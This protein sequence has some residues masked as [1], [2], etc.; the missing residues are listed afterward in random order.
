MFPAPTTM[1]S[2]SPS[3]CTATIS[4]ASAATVSGSSPYSRSPIRASP[5]SLSRRRRKAS[6]PPSGAR[7]AASSGRRLTLPG[8]REPPERH[9]ACAGLGERLSDRQR[10]IVDPRLV[11]ED[12]AGL[13]GEETPCVHAVPALL[14]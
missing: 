11:G 9:D 3:P 14:P 6:V 2:S 5:E 8:D 12:T 10:R 4:R 13:R 1:A 7:P